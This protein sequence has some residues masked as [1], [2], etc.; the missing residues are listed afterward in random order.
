M[1]K[2]A[3][4][5]SKVVGNGKKCIFA[6]YALWVFVFEILYNSILY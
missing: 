6:K 3:N 4:K 5:V 2:K 1:L